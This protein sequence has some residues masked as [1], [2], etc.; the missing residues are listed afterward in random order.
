[1]G[2]RLFRYPNLYG[3]SMNSYL[4]AAVATAAMVLLRWVLD[5]WMGGDLPL[6]T[7]FGAVAASVWYGGY[8]PALVATALGFMACNYLFMEPRGSFAI[9][10]AHPYIGLVLYLLTCS[11]IIGLGEGMR[12]AQRQTDEQRELLRVTVASIGDAVM[13]TD[14]AGQVTSLNPVAESL[15]GWTNGD[16]VGRPL[17][18]VF[19]I[20]NE[21]T[22]QAVGN[23]VTKVLAEGQIVGLANHT[24]LI[25][26]DGTER[27]I[28]DS[29]APIR[30]E[31]G[32]IVGVVLVFRDITERRRAEQ[33]LRQT[34]ERNRSVVDHILDGII[35]IDETGTVESFNPAAET[36]F[37]YAVSE[38]IGQNVKMLMPEPYRQAH[39]TYIANYL[40]TGEARIIGVG[41]EVVGRRTDGSTFPMELAV[42]TF[43]LDRRRFFTGIVRDITRRQ[44][45]EE[46]LKEADRRKDEFLATLAHELR[47][48]LAPLRNALELLRRAED[49][50]ALIER[51]RSIMERQVGLMV[52][53]VDD[54]LDVSRISRGRLQL[55]K[56]RVELAAVV[57]SAVETAR[58]LIEM[59]AHELIVT[60]PPEPISLNADSTRLAQVFSNLL[61]NA[62]K[63]TE[64]GGHI[65]L[66]A[67]RSG[68]QAVI[69]VRDTGIGIAAEHLSQVFEMFSQVEPALE[70]SEGGLGIGL[71]LVRGLV[72]LHGGAIEAHSRGPGL[73]SEFIVRLPVAETRVQAAP[74][75]GDGDGRSPSGLKRR[76]LVVDDNRDTADSLEMVL[77]LMGHDTH[78]AH[79]GLEALQVAATFRPHVVLLD[80]GLPKMNGYETAR[81][82]RE[83]PWGERIALI[84]LTGWGQEEDKRRALEAGFDH[85]LTK[86]MDPSAL[87]KLLGLIAPAQEP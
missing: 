23:P 55:R 32:R 20:V 43:H 45:A 12:L 69:S 65:W 79:D 5:P 46:A 52:R 33:E 2:K 26:R 62:A 41:R 73:G 18:E 61:N 7:L 67:E 6:V 72:E 35:T 39:D 70:R 22:R 84:A 71:A 8:R 60:L 83:E 63:Y 19:R 42:S 40:G 50:G 16:A 25:A 37:G 75:P 54:L 36:L 29:A 17:E 27:P 44:Q 13:T 34:E 24:V 3:A 81:A 66:T 76:I 87:E 82:I 78:A 31:H 14:T 38:V 56:E 49:D 74:K 21:Q 11:V 47:N 53:L 80:I 64:R 58:P 9:S 85:H 30:E 59:S 57:Q 68:G 10:H 51:A 15:I 1:M 28:D 86:P 4:V 48:P 77:R